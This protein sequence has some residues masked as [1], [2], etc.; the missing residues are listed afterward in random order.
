MKK[1][2]FTVLA[3]LC[4]GFALNC[5]SVP[6]KNS[7]IQREWMLISFENYT[8][9]DLIKNNAKIDLTSTIENGKI[10]GNAFMGCNRMFFSS[11]FKANGKMKIS[12]IAGTEMMCQNIKLEDDFSKSFKN[13]T[14]YKVEGHFLRLTDDQGHSMKFIAADWD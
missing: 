10:K 14:N 1:I 12:G 2:I 4:L 5:S 8:K 13:M 7:Q 11:E 6:V 9:E 3:F